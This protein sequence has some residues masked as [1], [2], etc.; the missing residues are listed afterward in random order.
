MGGHIGHVGPR[1]VTWG[2][3]GAWGVHVGFTWGSRGGPLGATWGPRGSPRVRM[4]SGRG[5]P[6]C[7]R[8]D[9]RW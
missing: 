8:R 4:L 2:H 9:R 3:G 6:P 1:G 5:A 7:R